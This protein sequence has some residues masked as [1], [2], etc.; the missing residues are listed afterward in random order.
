MMRRLK[1]LLGVL[2]LLL[3]GCAAPVAPPR[4]Y[5]AESLEARLEAIRREHNVPALAA[6]V[7]RGGEVT[8]IGAVGVRKAGSDAPVT[9]ADRFHVGSV[10]KSMTAILAARLVQAGVISWDLTVAEALPELADGMNPAFRGVTIEQLLAHRAGLMPLTDPGEDRE[11]WRRLTERIGT[12]T[13]QRRFLA[14]SVLAR[15]PAYPPGSEWAYS[16]TDY[17]VAGAMLESITGQSWETLMQEYVFAPLGITTAGFGP[18]GTPGEVIDQPWGHL[19]SLGRLVAT[20][21]TPDADNPPSIAP[22]GGVH[23]S[24][25]DYA[26]YAAA[27]LLAL[28]GDRSFLNEES[29]A[30][31]YTPQS[32]NGY[33]LGWLNEPNETAGAPTV[34]HNGSNTLFFTIVAITPERDLA[35]L[36]VTNAGGDRANRAVEATLTALLAE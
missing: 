14:E 25:E 5:P 7:I 3:V 19:A 32:E 26:R 13:E 21:P 27:N 29:V 4:D 20:E 22:A 10:T 31:L 36:A 33:A 28:R 35:V 8:Q 16:N 23:F 15:A 12:P 11:L 2:A 34:W 6:A 1:G 18:P 17:A 30:K 24:V 9:T